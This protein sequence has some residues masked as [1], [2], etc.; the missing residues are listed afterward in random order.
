MGGEIALLLCM[1][2]ALGK[3]DYGEREAIGLEC[4]GR[5]RADAAAFGLFRLTAMALEGLEKCSDN[6]ITVLLKHFFVVFPMRSPYS[7]ASAAPPGV[8][9]PL[10]DVRP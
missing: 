8:R 1:Q 10:L 4:G 7:G 3:A 6:Q 2:Q 9:S 5:H